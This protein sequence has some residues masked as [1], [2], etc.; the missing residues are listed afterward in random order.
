MG[1]ACG[2]AFEKKTLELSCQGKPIAGVLFASFGDPQGS[3]GSFIKGTCDAEEDVL[4][5]LQK[6]CV[7][8]DSCSIEVTEEKLGKTTCG[9]IVKRLAVEAVC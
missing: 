9:D 3:C 1:I 6:E 5:I 2:N 8:N 4:P 7:G